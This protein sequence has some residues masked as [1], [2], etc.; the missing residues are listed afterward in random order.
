MKVPAFLHSSIITEE[1]LRAPGNNVRLTRWN[2]GAAIWASVY[3]LGSMRGDLAHEPLSPPSKLLSC[4]AV[5]KAG[6]VAGRLDGMALV[7]TR[8]ALT[9]HE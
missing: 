5:R 9:P 2:I 1:M 7:L 3:L 4:S 6:H 8:A